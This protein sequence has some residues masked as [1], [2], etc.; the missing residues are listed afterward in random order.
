MQA[1][2]VRRQPRASDWE[3]RSACLLTQL[4]LWG[5]VH[6]QWEM[7][8][9]VLAQT[10]RPGLWGRGGLQL[11]GSRALL[12]D[13]CWMKENLQG[14]GSGPPGQQGQAGAERSQNQPP[15]LKGRFGGRT[16]WLE[17]EPLEAS[18]R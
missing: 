8:G 17:V 15:L 9:A 18:S 6:T 14:S 5:G 11:R 13:G 7:L 1:G 10:L 3:R 4:Q 12:S 16:W 2:S